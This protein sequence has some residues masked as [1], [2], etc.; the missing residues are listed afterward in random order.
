MRGLACDANTKALTIEYRH[1]FLDAKLQKQ[2]RERK[3]A[4]RLLQSAKQLLDLYHWFG[5]KHGAG[6]A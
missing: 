3:F 2:L 1:Y 5:K 4:D 6:E